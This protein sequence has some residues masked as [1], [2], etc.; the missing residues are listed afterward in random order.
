MRARHILSALV[1]CTACARSSNAQEPGRVGL[2]IA[3][4]ASV[5][6]VWEATDNLAVR[7][8]FAFS[9]A[10]SD[11]LTSS[12]NAAGFGVSVLLYVRKWDA[13]RAYV[14]PRFSYMRTSVA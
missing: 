12:S 9:Q 4:P 8:D 2:T 3:F 13:L 14:A 11:S 5:G 7:P 10:S 6:I 1:I